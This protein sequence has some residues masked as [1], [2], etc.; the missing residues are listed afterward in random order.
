MYLIKGKV[1]GISIRNPF[2]REL[3]EPME[4][5]K[6]DLLVSRLRAGDASVCHTIIEHHLRLTLDICAKYARLIPSKVDDMVGHACLTL[7]K[8]V[9]TEIPLVD[10]NIT[11]YLVSRIHGALSDFVRRDSVVPHRKDSTIKPLD[12][13]KGHT[14]TRRGQ[15]DMIALSDLIEHCV[16]TP[17]EE[18]VIG[19][20]REGY[21]DPEIAN[22]LGISTSSVNALKNRVY[23]RFCAA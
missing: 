19:L 16:H 23:R 7:A 21:K 10:N 5:E 18:K 11:P 12:S 6:L 13:L 1:K 17:E 15:Q 4:P 20:R 9:T 22:I 3:P 14:P 2:G 8:T